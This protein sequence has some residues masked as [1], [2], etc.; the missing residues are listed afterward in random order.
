MDLPNRTTRD[1]KAPSMISSLQ[2][3]LDAAL[4]EEEEMTFDA[5]YVCMGV[6]RGEF[7][8]PPFHF[9]DIFLSKFFTF[10][11]SYVSNNILDLCF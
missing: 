2:A 10:Y 5:M 4:Q 3:A 11:C 9:N 6:A 8:Y 1:Y 7:G